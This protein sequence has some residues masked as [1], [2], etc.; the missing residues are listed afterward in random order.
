MR[1]Y[2]YHPDEADVRVFGVPESGVLVRTEAMYLGQTREPVSSEW[3]TPPLV[4]RHFAFADEWFKLNATFTL[5]GELM[6]TGPEGDSFAVN[7]DIATPLRWVGSNASA[8]DL[9]LDVLVR[10]D[11]SYRIVDRPEFED[12]LSRRLI[13]SAEAAHAEE[14]LTSLLGWITSGRLLD[15]MTELPRDLAGEAPPPLPF[16]RAPLVDVPA[17]APYVRATW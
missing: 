17:V 14:G 4:L 13:S 5:D 3:S 11:G 1:D 16:S 8:V 12:A 6:E 15:L 7:C 10:L 2:D 9:F